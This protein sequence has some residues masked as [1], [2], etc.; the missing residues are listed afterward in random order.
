MTINGRANGRAEVIE[1]DQSTYAVTSGRDAHATVGQRVRWRV[2][3]LSPDDPHTFHLHGHAWC[4]RASIQTNG[5]CPAGSLPID[6]VD[7]LPAQ[8]VT[9]DFV[10]QHPGRWMYHCHIVDH[11]TDG[12]VAFYTVDET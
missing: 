2:L 8:G 7:L 11:V 10:E 9:F 12:M 5:T 4:D 6:N 1:L 3:N